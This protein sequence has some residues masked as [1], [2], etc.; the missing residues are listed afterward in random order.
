MNADGTNPTNLTNHPAKDSGPDWSPDGLQIAF[1]SDRDRKD[2]GTK[3][4]EI[5]VMNADGTNPINLTN[6]PARD[7]S[8]SWGSVR[9]LR[10]FFKRE[11]GHLMGKNQARQYLRS[12]VEFVRN[13]ADR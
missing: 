3:N 13:L 12:E 2:D 9:P 11:I 5:Y 8:P 4:V 1:T 6:H 10:S 7:S